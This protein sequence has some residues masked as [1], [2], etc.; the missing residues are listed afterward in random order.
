MR[1]IDSASKVTSAD[2]Q[3]VPGILVGAQV[4]DHPEMQLYSFSYEQDPLNGY[5]AISYGSDE[6]GM[7]YFDDISVV[8]GASGVS[9]SPSYG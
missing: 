8:N 6:S 7:V 9:F 4:C 5:C 2:G 3:P 1:C